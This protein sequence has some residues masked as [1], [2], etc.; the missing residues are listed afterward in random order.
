MRHQSP[1]SSRRAFLCTGAVA[2]AH[3]WVPRPVNGY[4]TA[5]VLEQL[6]SGR[7]QVGMSKW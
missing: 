1:S 2:A 6:S 3:V 7:G 4:S 5:D